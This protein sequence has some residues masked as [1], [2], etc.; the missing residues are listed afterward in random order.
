MSSTPLAPPRSF[1]STPMP[2]GKAFDRIAARYDEDFTE[3]LVGRLQR[4]Q[5]W[6][7]LDGL[8]PPSARILDLGCGTGADAIHLAR[9]GCE[10]HAVDASARMITE[11]QRK[12]AAAGL[13]N[14]ITTQVGMMEQSC[15]TQDCAHP[16]DGAISNFGALNCVA[17]LRPVATALS[18]LI[19]PGGHLALCLISRF[20]LWETFSYSV[21]GRFSKAAR[22]WNHGS[23]TAS[24]DGSQRFPVYYHPVR[25]VLSA[26]EPEFQLTGRS[27]IGVLVPPSYLETAAQKV[28][29]LTTF[30]HHM[31][32]F[33]A[34]WPGLRAVADHTLLVFTRG[35]RP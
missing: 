17:E 8:F 3:S 14:R 27:G 26:F 13:T 15:D 20:C 21:Q 30:A 9:L 1:D 16:Y 28:R 18:R 5:V 24:L 23:T 6:R 10:V 19:R 32:Q 12:I 11:A 7:Q 22:R 35:Q 25:S 34:R 2:A 29:R 33:I 31:D 4:E